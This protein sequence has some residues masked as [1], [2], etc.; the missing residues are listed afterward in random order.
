MKKEIC[1]IDEVQ[2]EEAAEVLLT[3]KEAKK[4]LFRRRIGA[5]IHMAFHIGLLVGLYLHFEKNWIYTIAAYVVGYYLFL[6]LLSLIPNL[7]EVFYPKYRQTWNGRDFIWI[8]DPDY[9]KRYGIFELIKNF[10]FY[11]LIIVLG[12]GL[13]LP[14]LPQYLLI[15]VVFATVAFVLLQ[16][17]IFPLLK[18]LLAII[19]CRRILKVAEKVQ[20]ITYRTIILF[21]VV[22]VIV[23]QFVYPLYTKPKMNLVK[24]LNQKS[25]Y[26]T[27]ELLEEAE[28]TYDYSHAATECE[29]NYV[30]KINANNMLLDTKT[31][32]KLTFDL[33]DAVWETKSEPNH[34]IL[35]D[36]TVEKG[37]PAVFTGTQEIDIKGFEGEG[38]V[39]V[40]LTD[41]KNGVGSGTLEI[42]TLNDKKLLYSSNFTIEEE[43]TLDVMVYTATLKKP[44]KL[45]EHLSVYTM[46]MK[47][48]IS[49]RTF[50]FYDWSF[51]I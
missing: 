34:K 29:I 31:Y 42:R 19:S 30:G 26:Y 35:S 15:I 25:P 38:I 48:D 13:L 28:V 1:K 8:E 41:V 32:A 17:L 6:L 39:T 18:D 43:W 40:K 37:K 11:A 3:E 12:V 47:I 20:T 21:V 9:S 23:M 7:G 49:K 24:V 45:S 50:T 51:T 16:T 14:L 5:I 22:L 27:Q 46:D 2:D 10:I 4:L 36:I 44:M 33:V